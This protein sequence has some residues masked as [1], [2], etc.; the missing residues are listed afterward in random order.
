MNQNALTL[1]E[2]EIMGDVDYSSLFRLLVTLPA[3]Q[4]ITFCAILHPPCL[5]GL[6]ILFLTMRI[7]STGGGPSGRQSWLGYEEC[8]RWIQLCYMGNARVECRTTAYISRKVYHGLCA[9]N[10]EYS[11]YLSYEVAAHAFDIKLDEVDIVT[12]EEARQSSNV[13]REEQYIPMWICG[14]A[15]RA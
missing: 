8:T 9:S 5:S 12:N 4:C 3:L 13:A 14:L 11:H 10:G 2:M 1:G 6:A 15:N 7:I